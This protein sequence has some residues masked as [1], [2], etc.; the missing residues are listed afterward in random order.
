MLQ[1]KPMINVQAEPEPGV[2]RVDVFLIPGIAVSYLSVVKLL[3]ENSLF[4]RRCA[5]AGLDHT[6]RRY[7]SENGPDELYYRD[8]LNNQKISYI[9]N[10]TLCDLCRQQAVQARMIV[11][12][13]MG[14][15]AALYAGGYYPYQTG[16]AVVEGAYR[17][18]ADHC[19]G[20]RY[21]MAIVLGFS[22]DEVARLLLEPQGGRVRIAMHNGHHN[23]VLAGDRD[24]LERCLETAQREGAIGIRR[25]LTRHP[26]HTEFLRGM[27]GG[28]QRFLEALEY[29]EPRTPVLSLVDG[30]A[31]DPGGASQAIVSAMVNPLHL[32]RTIDR[33][34]RLKGIQSCYD[35]GPEKSMQKL[36]RYIDRSV[37]VRPVRKVLFP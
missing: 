30:R 17:M 8:S 11:G 12:Y 3:Q 27:A 18:V 10:A 35:M 32:D 1:T 2:R 24:A 22:R 15:Y 13:S 4:R 9:A 20:H 28:F 19:R 36:V 31:V 21:G 16:L 33:A 37:R 34:C 23:F 7:L 5:D 25:I 29:R 26:Y 6:L 14:L